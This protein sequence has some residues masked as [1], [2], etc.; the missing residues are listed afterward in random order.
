M[1]QL[2]SEVFNPQELF[3]NHGPGDYHMVFLYT[4]YIGCHNSSQA[5]RFKLA[6]APQGVRLTISQIEGSPKVAFQATADNISNAWF[7]QWS[8][9]W[10]EG[11]RSASAQQNDT[12]NLLSSKR[13]PITYTL[14]LENDVECDKTETHTFFLDFGVEGKVLHKPTQFTDSSYIKDLAIDGWHWNFGD[15]N[16]TTSQ[17]P[18][19]TYASAGTYEVTLTITQGVITYSLR[20][21][22][23]IFPVIEVTP[24]QPYLVNFDQ[25][26]ASWVNR[27][28]VQVSGQTI[29]RNSWKLQPLNTTG[30][31]TGQPGNVWVTDN[32]S[33]AA[34]N[35]TNAH[36]YNNEQSYVES[37][38]FDITALNL[39]LLMFRYWSDTDEGSDGAVLLYTIDDGTT[40]Q[41]LGEKDQG[42]QWYNRLFVLGN[43]GKSSGTDS[44]E[45]NKTWIG[46]SGNA[47]TTDS[48]GWHTARLDL[49]VVKQQMSDANTTH[50]RI[51]FRLAFGS[52]SDTP[53]DGKYEGFAFDNFQ[54]Y[55][56]NRRALLE[57]F[58]NQSL[59][60][61]AKAAHDFASVRAEAISIHYHLGFPAA[62]VIKPAKPQR[63]KWQG[64]LLW[65]AK[66]PSYGGRWANER[67]FAMAVRGRH[68]L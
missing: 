9:Q 42:I 47:Q 58:G 37:P 35:D 7:W 60:N 22:V 4:D 30:H 64:F 56:R 55:N 3:T 61:D 16:K 49:D 2:A 21:Q 8:W 65:R 29:A 6:N 13:Q 26:K 27:G 11:F 46:W 19:H 39:P 59:A 10:A 68:P 54:L 40:W 17:H 20:K 38:F 44:E 52:N 1:Y 33:D 12:L 32:R 5:F 53:S 63:P 41:R 24:D 36:F 66:S 15:G 48:L 34:R 23:S 57:Y 25:G 31:I 50:Q 28:T 43:P 67:Y 45:V 18:Q 51:R 62:D 14:K